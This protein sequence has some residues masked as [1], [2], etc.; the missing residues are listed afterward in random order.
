MIPDGQEALRSDCEAL[1]EFYT[2]LEDP[3]VLDDV[4]NPYAWL[5]SNPFAGWQGVEIGRDGVV[6][7]VL[8]DT[9]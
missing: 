8:S 4:D 1:W 5:P 2:N 6:A 9:G 7:V 3:G